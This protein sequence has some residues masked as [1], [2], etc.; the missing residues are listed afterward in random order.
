MRSFRLPSPLRGL[1]FDLDSTLYEDPVYA[2]FQ[3]RVLVERL[4]GERGLSVEALE[5]DLA[6]LRSERRARGEG[7]TSLGNLFLALGVP[8]PTSVAW[9]EE[10]IR[11]ADWLSPDPRLDAALGLLAAELPLC[12]LTNNP[13][14]VG[15]ASLEALGVA[16]RFS[17]VIGLDDTGR[18]KPDPAPFLLAARRLGLPAP[19]LLS[20]GDRE[21]VDIAPAL[22]LGMG[23]LLVSSAEEVYALPSL[24]LSR[25]FR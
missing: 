8:I 17:L 22:A 15:N 16:E 1:I 19:G 2:R 21:E 7:D 12:L 11:P 6:R 3:T 20:I 4:A 18:S 10:L 23:G 5:T 14:S 13:R 24:L 25:T 9:R